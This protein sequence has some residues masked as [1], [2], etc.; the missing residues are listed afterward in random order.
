[1]LQW[2]SPPTRLQIAGGWDSTKG[3][4]TDSTALGHSKN[5]QTN[6]NFSL[7]SNW[8]LKEPVPER[9]PNGKEATEHSLKSKGLVCAVVYLSASALTA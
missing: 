2:G 4:G 8:N 1:M 3:Q 5:K 7:K 6:K 9:L